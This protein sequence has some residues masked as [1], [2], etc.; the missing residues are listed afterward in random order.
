MDVFSFYSVKDESFS[1]PFS[2][3][4]NLPSSAS[5]S[6]SFGSRKHIQAS[7]SSSSTDRSH[8]FQPSSTPL[9]RYSPPKPNLDRQAD[10]RPSSSIP[11]YVAITVP[12]TLSPPLKSS[13]SRFLEKKRCSRLAAPADATKDQR[14]RVEGWKMPLGQVPNVLVQRPRSHSNSP[15]FLRITDEVLAPYGKWQIGSSSDDVD[16]LASEPSSSS[17]SEDLNH[18]NQTSTSSSPMASSSSSSSSFAGLT[19]PRGASFESDRPFIITSSSS[20]PHLLSNLIK[21]SLASKI[22]HPT[23]QPPSGT[24]VSPLLADDWTTDES[25]LPL[26]APNASSSSYAHGEVPE[27]EEEHDEQ[28]KRK[29]EAQWAE[30]EL[31][32]RGGRGGVLAL[33]L[34]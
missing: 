32:E 30:I 10:L 20:N 15:F 2:S 8:L 22:Y 25:F 28:L 14:N 26:F 4:Y 34:L 33:E 24:F 29:V 11:Q 19:T 13:S 6:S 18:V 16:A 5:S 17:N 9:P 31:W 23:P 21:E 7:S 1:L 3:R 27:L 12:I